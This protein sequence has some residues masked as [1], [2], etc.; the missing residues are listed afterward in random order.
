[1]TLSQYYD[2]A[3]KLKL[4]YPDDQAE[5]DKVVDIACR[6]TYNKDEYRTTISARSWLLRATW[7]PEGTTLP[8]WLGE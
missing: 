7:N 5:I 8:V 3:D 6:H 1:M 2:L 4:R